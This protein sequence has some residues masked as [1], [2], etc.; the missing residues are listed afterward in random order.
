MPSPSLPEF[1]RSAAARTPGRRHSAA[2]RLAAAAAV[3]VLPL[4]MAACTDN[5]APASTAGAAGPIQV[6]STGDACKM[7]TASAKS[8]NLTFAVQNDGEQVTE[9][10]LLAEDGLRILGEVENIGPG[11]TRNLVVTVPAGKYTTACKPGMEGDGIRAGFEVTES[12]SQPAVDSDL[13]ALSDHGTAQY[14][15][16][17]KDQTEQLLAGTKKF[18][19]AYASGDAATAKNL[20]AAT[21]MHW[22]RIEPVAESFGDLD[23]KLD[24]RE[25]DLAEGEEWTGWH[26]AEKDLFPPAGF[27]PLAAPEREKLAAQLVADTEELAQRTRTV[28]LTADKLGNGAKE[29]LDEVATGKVTGE[30]EI[31]S[32]TDLW[33]FQANVD[34]ARIAFENLKPVLAQKDP[35]LSKSLDTKF[36]ALQAELKTHAK[37]DGFAYY[38]ELSPEQVQRLAALVDSLGEP[39]SNLTA[40]VV[41]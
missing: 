4:T 6:T 31:W 34:G 8:G 27:Q 40:A 37:G 17:V 18:A 2:A 26:R 22:E 21:R 19:E 33:D 1:D 24:A 30:E 39:L 14:V 11:L 13:K 35:E 15:A 16:Y 32:H 25:A 12:G 9:F 7:S 5:A 10:Y 29:L 23:P 28:E 41:L 3:A 38:N 20:Y 36:A